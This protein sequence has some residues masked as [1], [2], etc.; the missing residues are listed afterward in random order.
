MKPKK[1]TAQQE[2]F[3]Q[4]YVKAKG[5][6]GAAS[7]AYR[8][9][10]NTRMKADGV[11]SAAKRLL[12][13]SPIRL[14]IAELQ[15]RAESPPAGPGRPTEYRD[16][17]CAQATH[18]TKLGATDVEL[19]EFFGVTE[20]TLNN[21]KHAHPEFF[22]SI[23]EGKIVTDMNVAVKLNQRAT[24][25]DYME[26][27]PIKLKQVKYKDGKKVAETEKVEIVEVRKVVPP[28][29]AAAIFWLTNR[30]RKQ[31]KHRV[32]N[33]VSGEDGKPIEL[34]A[35]L[36][37]NRDVARAVLDILRG[38]V[39]GTPAAPTEPPSPQQEG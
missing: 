28:D 36:P 29:T 26:A 20:Q 10:Y 11:A 24:G 34:S 22:E 7:N 13:Q 39:P 32:S 4:A 37:D 5:K 1:L 30:R 14:R 6:R 2:A 3:C 19:A 23:K 9:A 21:W 12:R 33:E 38:A 15:R 16:E 17:Y 25:F 35:P 8:T 31:W 18:L 27:H